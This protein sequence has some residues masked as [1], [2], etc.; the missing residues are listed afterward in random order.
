MRPPF[1]TDPDLAICAEAV[2]FAEDHATPS[3]E[4]AEAIDQA[5]HGPDARE[6][7]TL[8]TCPTCGIGAVE[9]EVKVALEL[10]A[11]KAAT[12]DAAMNDAIPLESEEL[13]EDDEET[14]G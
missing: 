14:R 12:F 8:V 1:K 6:R 2:R 9:P 10:Q 4:L 13:D 5:Q 3:P 11:A 7:P